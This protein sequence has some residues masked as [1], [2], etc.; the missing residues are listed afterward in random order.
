MFHLKREVNSTYPQS[1][2]LK[3]DRKASVSCSLYHHC[4]SLTLYMFSF[5]VPRAPAGDVQVFAQTVRLLVTIRPDS[6]PS[7][8][9]ILGSLTTGHGSRSVAIPN[10]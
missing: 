6:A 3:C 5:P 9:E 4:S 1:L 8:M 10:V 7:L 2:R